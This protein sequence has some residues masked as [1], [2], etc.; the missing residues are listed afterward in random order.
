MG[1]FRF[2]VRAGCEFML[3]S[4]GTEEEKKKN[5]AGGTGCFEWSVG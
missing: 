1:S 2:K 4:A 5:G 3:K